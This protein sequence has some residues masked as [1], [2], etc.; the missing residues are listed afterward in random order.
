MSKTWTG[1]RDDNLGRRIEDGGMFDQAPFLV[2]R[3]D[4]EDWEDQYEITGHAGGHLHL[5]K[6]A[7]PGIEIIASAY[8]GDYQGS[9]A[10]AFRLPDGRFGVVSSYYGSCSGCDAFDGVEGERLVELCQSVLRDTLVFTYFEE[11]L[12]FLSKDDHDEY[13]WE[14]DD[15]GDGL[16][17][18]KKLAAAIRNDK[19]TL[20][21]MGIRPWDGGPSKHERGI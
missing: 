4:A 1:E 20:L 10:M 11:M 3:E 13:R 5:L 16:P 6:Y 9:E 15:Y 2:Q 21:G 7:L 8:V 17:I 19:A 14:I 12:A 18:G